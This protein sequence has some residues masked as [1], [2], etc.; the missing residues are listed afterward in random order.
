M[1]GMAVLVKSKMITEENC[2]KI[3]EQVKGC[4]E[5]GLVACKS[6]CDVMGEKVEGGEEWRS[7]R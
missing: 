5:V 3:V 2:N 6:Y 4:G 1:E 7:K